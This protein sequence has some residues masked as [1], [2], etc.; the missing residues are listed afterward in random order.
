MLT[1]EGIRN[2]IGEY[3]AGNP[4]EDCALRL[5]LRS[6]DGSPRSFGR[7]LAEVCL[8]ADWGSIKLMSFPFDARVAMAREIK[9]RGSV[10][11]AI[12]SW[13][14]ENLDAT[15]TTMLID[16]I[17]QKL[18]HT[19]LLQ[20]PK[21]HRRQLSFL[22]KYLHWR[23]NGAFPIWDTNARA[24]LDCNDETTSWSAYTNWVNRVREEATRHKVCCLEQVRSPGE[25]LL[26][27]FDKALYIVGDTY[28]LVVDGKYVLKPMRWTAVESAG[29]AL[30]LATGLAVSAVLVA[31]SKPWPIGEPKSKQLALLR[32]DGAKL[33]MQLGL[34]TL[35][36]SSV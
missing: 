3:N 30:R 12:H 5:A 24:A 26:R 11:E 18:R 16:A 25:C 22:S 31:T 35:G 32:V 9:V 8:I 28:R 19:S 34:T 6:L 21:P 4:T 13:Q 20:P 2:A 36:K 14:C 29:Q 23:V 1:C 7:L 10:L 15:E 27:T 33:A 17:E